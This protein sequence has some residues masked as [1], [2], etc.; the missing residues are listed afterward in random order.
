MFKISV[1]LQKGKKLKLDKYIAELLY[2]YDC[3]I[4]PGFGGFVCNYAPARIHPTQHIFIPPSKNIV[5][6]RSL[7]NNDGLL[8]NHICKQENLGFSEACSR[9]AEFVK[10]IN[11]CINSGKKFE[12]KEIGHLYFDVEKN[13][14][15]SPSSTVNYLQ[16]SFGLT[17]FQSPAIKRSSHYAP[18]TVFVDRPPLP[19]AVKSRKVKKY[20]PVAI[21]LP[22]IAVLAYLPF[23]TNAIK[24]LDIS[25]SGFNPFSSAKNIYIPRVKAFESVKAKADVAE[26]M[27]DLTSKENT[28]TE[29]IKAAPA[30][31]SNAI[32]LSVNK[33]PSIKSYYIIA[34]CFE[35]AENAKAYA[36]Q[37]TTK[38]FSVE[39]LEK[40]SAGLYRVSCGAHGSK[41]DAI[42]ALE[43]IKSEAPSAWVLKN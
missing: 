16:D 10:E 4:I 30:P 33:S 40:N 6:N 9:I 11:E 25:Y 20:W 17:E 37:L 7:N 43:T 28:G 5:F 18:G 32:S 22:L 13:I 26:V 19:S 38:G 8:A 36:Q 35:I 3:I 34:G 39:I 42:S 1:S 29:V 21:A 23:K 2:S 41:A 12:L 24:G 27:F 15:F 14:Q 31:E